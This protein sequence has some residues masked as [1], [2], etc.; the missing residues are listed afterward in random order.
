MLA[1][2]ERALLCVVHNEDLP[3]SEERY[4]LCFHLQCF[5]YNPIIPVISGLVLWHKFWCFLHVC[6][7]SGILEMPRPQETLDT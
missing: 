1:P 2:N 4:A 5:P 6:H 3:L 7:P